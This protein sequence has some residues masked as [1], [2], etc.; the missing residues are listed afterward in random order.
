MA[1]R[2]GEE[3]E[4]RVLSAL[5][6]ADLLEFGGAQVVEPLPDH[7]NLPG[8]LADDLGDSPHFLALV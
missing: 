5:A 7:T 2:L 8:A 6:G 4:G 1:C 3:R